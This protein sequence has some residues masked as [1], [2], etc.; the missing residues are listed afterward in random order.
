MTFVD[1]SECGLGTAHAQALAVLRRLL[2][3][4]PYEPHADCDLWALWQIK[5]L[6][7]NKSDDHDENHLKQVTQLS[8]PMRDICEVVVKV[9]KGWR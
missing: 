6:V 9:G 1:L 8:Q 4:Y 5:R 7:T 2:A 3:E